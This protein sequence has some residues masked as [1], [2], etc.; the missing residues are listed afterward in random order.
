[1]AKLEVDR[2]VDSQEDRIQR[3]EAN[4]QE[5]ATKVAILTERTDAGFDRLSAEVKNGFQNLLH[6]DQKIRA[7]YEN[8]KNV[9]DSHKSFIEKALEAEQKSKRRL[10]LLK[11][12]LFTVITGATAVLL[13]ELVTWWFK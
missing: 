1:M 2:L 13:K 3:L 7:N 5:V 11:K 4:Q 12:G 9:V 10:E 8:L 6:E